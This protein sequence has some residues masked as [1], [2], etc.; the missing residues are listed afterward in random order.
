L[1]CK[2]LAL[3]MKTGYGAVIIY[4]NIK[5]YPGYLYSKA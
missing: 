1:S 5:K 4:G 3:V 2:Y